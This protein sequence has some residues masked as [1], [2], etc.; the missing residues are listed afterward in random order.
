MQTVRRK[1]VGEP[2]RGVP[3]LMGAGSRPDGF[4]K[5]ACVLFPGCRV[6]ML[7]KRVKK[8]ILFTW[9]GP[10]V[11]RGIMKKVKIFKIFVYMIIFTRVGH[12][13]FILRISKYF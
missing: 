12:I 8:I 2:W 7:M 6:I 1:A 3:L 5:P 4:F 13:Y 9:A 11:S 10:G